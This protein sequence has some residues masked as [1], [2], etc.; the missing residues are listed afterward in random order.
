[1]IARGA[2][3]LPLDLDIFAPSLVIIP[4]VNRFWNGSFTS[5][6]PRSVSALQKKRA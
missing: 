2:T 5:R 3:T 4:C 6:T 1:M